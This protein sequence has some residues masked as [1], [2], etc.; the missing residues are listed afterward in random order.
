MYKVVFLRHGESV[1]NKENKFTGWF[2]DDLAT[3][4]FDNDLSERGVTEAK[5]AALVLIKEGFKFDIV[6][7]SFLR[8]ATRTADIVLKEMNTPNVPIEK[9]WKLNERFYGA[10][11]GLN[12]AETANK[13]GRGLVHLW[14]RS[15]ATRPPVMKKT[16]KYWPGKDPMYKKLNKNQLPLS[17]SLKDASERVLPY[18]EKK[19]VPEIKSKKSVLISGHGSV[20]RILVKH[21]NKL[22][23]KE[24][25]NLN[26]PTGIPLVFELN[27]RMKAIDSYY[28]ADDEKVTAAITKVKDQIK[29]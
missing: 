24:V 28:L 2:D 14:R 17:E 15:W 20:T 3:D 9:S 18:W 23:D 10:L 22:N 21:L 25:E 13:Y 1:W 11:Q 29:I 8:R 27:R 12:K 16:S 26:I 4:W 7:T 19:I 6:F 5:D